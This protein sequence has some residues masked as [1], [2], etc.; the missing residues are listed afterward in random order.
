ML[1]VPVQVLFNNSLCSK[2][3]GLVAPYNADYDIHTI[4]HC[5]QSTICNLNSFSKTLCLPLMNIE[6][7]ADTAFADT[8]YFTFLRFA[9]TNCSGSLDIISASAGVIG[10]CIPGGVFH[11]LPQIF[12][13]SND[14]VYQ[15][16][17]NDMLCSR[18]AFGPFPVVPKGM[19]GQC[20]S[21][22]EQHGTSAV[23]RIS[24]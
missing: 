7:L 9:T 16:T 1:K 15:T 2:P 4:N 17:F 18:K 20:Y 14:M 8:V 12:T 13:L 21:R 5:R 10:Q 24:K 6:T 11:P 19:L 23:F 22:P 3:T